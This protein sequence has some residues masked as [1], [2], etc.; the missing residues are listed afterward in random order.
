MIV[1]VYQH[2]LKK[3]QKE[4]RK[5]KIWLDYHNIKPLRKLQNWTFGK[6][7]VKISASCFV[8]ETCSMEIVLL[9]ICER[10]WCSRMDRCFVR[11]RVLWLVARLRQL[12][13]SSKVRH[14]ILGVAQWMGR[15]LEWRSLRRWMMA[16]ISRNAEETAIYLASVELRAVIDWILDFHRIGQPA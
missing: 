12:M 8:V 7:F 3:N 1:W 15:P 16:M 14:F 11:G 10:K 4:E 9:T 5:K 2:E 6:G 13:L